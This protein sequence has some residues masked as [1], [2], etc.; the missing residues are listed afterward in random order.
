M[1]KSILNFCINSIVT[2]SFSEFRAFMLFASIL[3]SCWPVENPTVFS[4]IYLSIINAAESCVLCD[5]GWCGVGVGLVWGWV[6]I[7]SVGGCEEGGLC[8][9]F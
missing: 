2:Y 6:V 5:V 8:Q 9:C 4:M 1:I 7:V 3:M